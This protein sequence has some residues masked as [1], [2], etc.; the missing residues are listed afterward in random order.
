M[1]DLF[2]DN[3]SISEFQIGKSVVRKTLTIFMIFVI[4][5]FIG[6]AQDKGEGSN[7]NLLTSNCASGMDYRANAQGTGVYSSNMQQTASLRWKFQAK[8]DVKSTPIMCDGLVYIGTHDGYV[9]AVDVETGKE[10]WKLKA[11]GPT[12]SSSISIFDGTIYFGSG[13]FLYAADAKSGRVVWKFEPESNSHSRSSLD[14][15]RDL[16]QGIVSTPLLTNGRVFFGTLGGIF[17]ALDSR[18]GNK[19]WAYQASGKIAMSP[20]MESDSVYFGDDNQFYAINAETGK[21]IWIFKTPIYR[22]NASPAISDGIVCF[23]NGPAIEALDINS[24]KQVWRFDRAFKSTLV[25]SPAIDDG[26]VF[27]GD[28]YKYY[29]INLKSGETEWQVTQKDE[30]SSSPAVAGDSVV[31]GT[32]SGNLY[33]FDLQTGKI[34]WE[35][36]SDGNVFS[37]AIYDGRIFF[38]S[39]TYLY[40]VGDQ[41][42]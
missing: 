7:D 27:F 28:G 15:Q 37:P 8:D 21:E 30:F 36:H 23:D 1:Y 41:Q 34:H 33:A 14:P 16:S 20:A 29:A 4:I 32:G 24:G 3:Y 42:T 35:F 13:N 25:G 17:Y 11:D 31:F 40:A 2:Q 18:T 26:K 5:P 12:I 10:K 39:G 9:Y 38:G 6:C 22:I 19:I